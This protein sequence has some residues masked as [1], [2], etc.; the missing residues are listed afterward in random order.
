MPAPASTTPPSRPTQTLGQAANRLYLAALGVIVSAHHW[1]RGWCSAAQST[2]SRRARVGA[3]YAAAVA[4]PMLLI[5]FVVWVL[6]S[7]CFE[8]VRAGR[9]IGAGPVGRAVYDLAATV[10]RPADAW[11]HQH[12]AALPASPA[13]LGW[14]WLAL[15]AVLYLAA[16]RGSTAGRFAWAILAAATGAAV[17][18]GSAA[19]SRSAALAVTAGAALLLAPSAYARTDRTRRQELAVG[20]TVTI[21]VQQFVTGPDAPLPQQRSA[22]A[23]PQHARAGQPDT[24][25]PAAGFACRFCSKALVWDGPTDAGRTWRAAGDGDTYC[26]QA[27]ALDTELKIV[28]HAHMAI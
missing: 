19:D 13:L 28:G 3:G 8:L 7:A 9:W 17:W 15:A 14:C 10:V 12:A 6:A 1:W 5:V 21:A 16:R 23:E 24:P 22:A 26:P 20:G 25:P 11:L 4:A 18:Q 27:P 2:S